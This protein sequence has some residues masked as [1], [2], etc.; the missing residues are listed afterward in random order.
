M[1]ATIDLASLYHVETKRINE[2]VIR[3][4]DKFPIRFSWILSIDETNKLSRSKFATLNI[5]RGEN[6]KYG[7]RV[8]TEQ[9]VYMLATILK[10]KEAIKVTIS[11]MDAFVKMRHYI[12][13]NK[14]ILSNKILLL[15]DK[16]NELL[17]IKNI[18]ICVD[19]HLKI[20]VRNVFILVKYLIVIY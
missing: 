11:I 5:K 16:I 9:G 10:S 8:F 19:H 7:A 1:K 15:E 6:I 2:V 18:Y 17:L 14:D 3:N 4:K 13:Y 20:K 12:N